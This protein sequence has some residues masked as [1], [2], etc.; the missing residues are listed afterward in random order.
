MLLQLTDWLTDWPTDWLTDWLLD[1]LT[2]WL[3][4]WL[5]DRLTDWLTGWPNDWLTGW[6]TDWLID[7]RIDWLTDWLIDG[8]TDWLT[9]YHIFCDYIYL[10]PPRFPTTPPGQ[11]IGFLG[12]ATKLHCDVVGYPTPEV[13]WNRSPPTPLPQDRSTVKN[14]SLHIN[15]T[16]NSDGGVYIC[17]ATNKHG[18]IIH[19]TFLKVEPVGK[20]FNY[21]STSASWKWNGY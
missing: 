9:D 13:K 2:D 20:L 11:G 17:T 15:D 21:Y 12:K 1:G 10:G 4:D 18:M 5:I 14:G 8:L 7:W 19:G 3:T 6:L 16:E